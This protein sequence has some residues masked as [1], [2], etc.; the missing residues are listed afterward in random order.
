LLAAI[1]WWLGFRWSRFIV[2]VLFG[3]DLI[4]IAIVILIYGWAMF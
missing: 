4:Y 2:L 3:L 1:L